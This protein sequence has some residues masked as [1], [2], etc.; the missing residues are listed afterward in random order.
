LLKDYRSGWCRVVE[1]L[2]PDGADDFAGVTLAEH[3]SVVRLLRR[4]FESLRPP[5]LR[6]IPGQVDGEELDLD[7]MV[8]RMADLAAGCEPS[9][10]IYVRRE[11]RERDVAAAFLVDLSGSTGRQLDSEDDRLRRVIDVEKEGLV[12][13]SEALDAI[14]D[15]YAI[16]GYSGQGRRL[17]DFVVLKEFDGPSGGLTGRR[18]GALAPL[19]QNRD[20][21]A[22][23]H[24]VRKLLAREAR[25]RLLILIS[26][27]KPLDDGYADEYSL[28]DTKM[29]LREARMKGIEPFCITVDRTAGDYLRR[30]YGEVRFLII[31]RASAL[32]ERLPKIYRQ[33]TKS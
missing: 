3:G 13:L 12:L 29:A 11:K 32:P 21:A 27:G 4:Y 2:G 1:R 31:D 24:A 15:Q 6:R 9:E 14:G 23:R 33:L 19:Q 30:M 5:G 22:I 20:G 25:H 17:V 26:D 8:G 7:A 18:I 16:Y 10:R 28:E